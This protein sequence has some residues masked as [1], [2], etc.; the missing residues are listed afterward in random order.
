MHYFFV[1]LLLFVVL[2]HHDYYEN[3]KSIK[4]K[5]NGLTNIISFICSNQQQQLQQ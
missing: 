1:L 3:R 4:E 5:L 2:H